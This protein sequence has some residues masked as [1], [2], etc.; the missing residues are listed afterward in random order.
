MLLRGLTSSKS[1]API[2][3]TTEHFSLVQT[4]LHEVLV[5][6]CPCFTAVSS[7]KFCVPLI[8]HQTPLGSEN[9]NPEPY[10]YARYTPSEATPFV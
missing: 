3:E 9:R 10:S 6:L 1:E 5:T 4:P 8:T 2:R 7:L